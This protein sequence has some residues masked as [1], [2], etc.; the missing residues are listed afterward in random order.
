VNRRR[1]PARG[2][3]VLA[4]ATFAVLL[5]SAAVAGQ[6]PPTNRAAPVPAPAAAT[7]SPGTPRGK[8]S[9]ALGVDIVAPRA[10]EAVFG[11]TEVRLRPRGAARRAELF[12]D[13]VWAAKAAPPTWRATVD[14]GGENIAH[15]LEAVVYDTPEGAGAAGASA[16]AVLVTGAV[17]A[18]LEIRVGLQQMYVSV[19]RGDGPVEGLRREDFALEDDGVA[20]DLV[21]FERGD[22]PL[23]AALLL[24]ASSSMSGGRLR[25]ALDGAR[26]FVRA[27]QPL[28]EAKL[29]LFNDRLRAES[30]FTSSIAVLAVSLGDLTAAGGTAL[31]DALYLALGRMRARQ[32]RK[33]VVLLS[34]GVDVESVLAME[35]VRAVARRSGAAVHWL[36]MRGDGGEIEG[37]R[38]LRSPW[39]GP[40]EHRREIE[41]LARL[42]EESGGRIDDISTVAE[43]EAAL[44]RLLR[45]LRAQYVLGYYPSATRGAGSWHD[46]RVALAGAAAGAGRVRTQRG[47]AEP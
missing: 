33:V 6:A 8:P 21:T 18:G 32:G 12:L 45:D 15:R 7:P 5:G 40:Q 38:A 13:G 29:M 35:Q 9:P 3:R 20:Q 10:D 23:T 43:V 2:T 4:S 47:Y 14:F 39:R 30:P 42:V 11:P 17:A 27:L 41:A 34:D 28:D 19:E 26:S 44:S 22:V 37:R 16:N 31:N 36:R 25:T 46:V 1:T 24:D